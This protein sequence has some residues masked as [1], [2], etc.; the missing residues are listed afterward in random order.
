MRGGSKDEAEHQEALKYLLGELTDREAEAFEQLYLADQDRFELLQAI[1]E[2]LIEDYHHGRLSPERRLLFERAY[3]TRPDKRDKIDFAKSLVG[4]ASLER[5]ESLKRDQSGSR[6]PTMSAEAP[7]VQAVPSWLSS[8]ALAIAASL[9]IVLLIAAVWATI[10]VIS[11]S[12]RLDE[13]ERLR[14]EMEATARELEQR[15]E[16]AQGANRALVEELQQVRDQLTALERRQLEGPAGSVLSLV[17]FPSTTRAGGQSARAQLT[18]AVATLDLKLEVSRFDFPTYAATVLRRPSHLVT[19]RGNLKAAR[20]AS[21]AVLGIKL[22]AA[23]LS[24]GE[25]VIT[26]N[27]IS[28]TGESRHAAEYAFTVVRE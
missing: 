12:N 25:Y 6:S 2:D 20:T 4:V 13:A 27:G 22:S 28:A 11:L 24:P 17:L 1:E 10:S 8:R 16:A 26:L 9:G 15:L 19:R 18:P 14:A 21:G 5:A 23:G 7:A 3:L